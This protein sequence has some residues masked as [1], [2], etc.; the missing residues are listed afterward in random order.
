MAYGVAVTLRATICTIKNDTS[1]GLL[2]SC[3]APSVVAGDL[4]ISRNP[5]CCIYF[6]GEFLL[7]SALDFFLDMNLP[8]DYNFSKLFILYLF[9]GTDQ[10]KGEEHGF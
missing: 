5:F 1:T 8:K 7:P 2:L 9:E 4:I 3:L 10:I 6:F